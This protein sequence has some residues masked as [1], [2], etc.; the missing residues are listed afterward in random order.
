MGEKVTESE[1]A[2]VDR[3]ESSEIEI[4]SPVD[5]VDTNN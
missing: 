1:V 4:S 3:I 5:E 2:A